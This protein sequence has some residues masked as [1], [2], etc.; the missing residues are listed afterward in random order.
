MTTRE[1]VLQRARQKANKINNDLA[2]KVVRSEALTRR[3]S[4]SPLALRVPLW[5]AILRGR[6]D[7]YVFV[8][9][10]WSP[11]G[12]L[13]EA[14]GIRLTV[15]GHE[16][17]DYDELPVDQILKAAPPEINYVWI[18][19]W[20][21]KL[22]SLIYFIPEFFGMRFERLDL[23]GSLTYRTGGGADLFILPLVTHPRQVHQTIRGWS[24][25]IAAG[26]EAMKKLVDRIDAGHDGQKEE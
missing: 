20:I 2:D 17:P 7:M 1:D 21:R 14:T 13:V 10:S 3:Y 19:D 15:S 23:W 12:Y 26:N 22:Q 25:S 4:A 5:G 9:Q 11:S 8:K 24:A 16:V 6:P 18:V